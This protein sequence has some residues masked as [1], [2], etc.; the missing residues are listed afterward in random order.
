MPGLLDLE[1]QRE[2]LG[3]VSDGEHDSVADSLARSL[4]KETQCWLIRRRTERKQHRAAARAVQ[5]FS[6]EAE[7]PDADFAWRQVA[8][9]S[10]M[11]KD[12]HEAVVGLAFCEQ[13]LRSS[14]VEGL[15]LAG[16]HALASELAGAWDVTLPPHAEDA[17]VA[18][19]A[20]L[21]RK[22]LALP[23]AFQVNFVA[24]EADIPALHTTL[25]GARVVGL[26]AEWSPAE[27]S[28]PSLLQLSTDAVAFLVD[29]GSLGGS[30]ALAVA[31][32]EIMVAESVMKVGFSGSSDLGRIA[33]AFPKLADVNRAR[34][35]A[36]IRDLEATRR[37]REDGLSKKQSQTGINLCSLAERHLG[38]PLDKTPQMSDW[39]R[40]PLTEMQTHY[41]AL[42]ALAPV[43]IYHILAPPLGRA[44]TA[45]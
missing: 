2:I 17:A 22:H 20:E 1:G 21:R 6:L 28:S 24:A 19:R 45:P 31:L 39:A 18:Q 7:F 25:L 42:D 3:T 32:R 43:Q 4:G 15:C 27:G 38:L 44:V 37:V 14:A 16:R 5:A 11:K 26:D 13:R 35:L 10:A 40:R 30:E 41:A 29:L 33:K 12:A 23:D 36:D 8:F 9:A 34:P